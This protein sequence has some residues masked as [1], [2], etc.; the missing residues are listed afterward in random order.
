MLSSSI[1]ATNAQV[2]LK[3]IT[4]R[5]R[6]PLIPGGAELLDFVDA[7]LTG[8]VAATARAAVAVAL[9]NEAVVDAAGVMG[10]FEM[11][12]R[13]ADGVGM[14]VGAGT[15]QRMADIITDLELDRYPHA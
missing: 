9:G 14:P 12:N 10:N 13:I 7:A 4:D 11:M 2:D 5:T 8:S 15:R 1:A 3:A 6:D